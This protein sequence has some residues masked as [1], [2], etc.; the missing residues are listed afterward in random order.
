[1]PNKLIGE[2][3]KEYRLWKSWSVSDMAK[4][5][6]TSRQNIESLESR[7]ERT[8]RYIKSLANVMGVTVDALMSGRYAVPFTENQQS[9]SD[10]QTRLLLPVSPDVRARTLLALLWRKYD[11]AGISMGRSQ[12][13]VVLEAVLSLLGDPDPVDM[14]R[15]DQDSG[16]LVN[17]TRDYL[18]A[19]RA[20][21]LGLK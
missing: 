19:R 10:I 20:V 5:V 21:Q 4:A 16:V 14:K 11:A 3:A 9:K 7:P 18:S 1:M 17:E 2:S 6:G 13:S 12:E 8:P 15:L